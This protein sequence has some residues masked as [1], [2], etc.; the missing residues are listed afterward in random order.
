M[1]RKEELL[2]WKQETRERIDQLQKYDVTLRTVEGRLGQMRYN[3][4]SQITH[5]AGSHQEYHELQTHLRETKRALKQEFPEV[6]A[7]LL[8][9][10]KAIRHYKGMV[11]SIDRHLET[12]AQGS[13]HEQEEQSTTTTEAG[14]SDL[15]AEANKTR[16]SE[17]PPPGE[18]HTPHKRPL[19]DLYG[20]DTE[21]E[22]RRDEPDRSR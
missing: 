6:P 14:W 15:V 17:P 9:I 5:M 10:E 12:L 8:G 20:P 18:Q 2:Q 4:N 19:R 11:A 1:S 7:T 21:P 13:D 16:E 3:M 22:R